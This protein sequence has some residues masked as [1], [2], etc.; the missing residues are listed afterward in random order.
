MSI[1]QPLSNSHLL[2]IKI[3]KDIFSCLDLYNLLL[4]VF[5]QLQLFFPLLLSIK[6]SYTC[7][8]E[9]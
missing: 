2:H 7:E 9:C 1:E 3:V 6:Q 4:I 8:D 5:T